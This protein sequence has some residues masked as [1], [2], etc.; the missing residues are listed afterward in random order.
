MQYFTVFTPQILDDTIFLKYGGQVGTSIPAQRQ[1]AYALAEELMTEELNSFLTP[2][3]VTGTF[4]WKGQNPIQLDFGWV[5]SVDSVS[6]QAMTV[7]NPSLLVLDDAHYQIRN[8]QYGLLDIIS[9]ETFHGCLPPYS[10]Q[11]VYTSGLLT[12]VTGT[13]QASPSILSALT[14]VAQIQLNEFDVSLSNESTGD[15][16][17]EF[18]IN[19]HYHEKRAK[20][21]RSAFGNSALAYRAANLVKRYRAK[22]SIGFH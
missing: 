13:V 5:T 16:G 2:T 15:V 14:I 8:A 19:Q 9:R 1:A 17:I 10:I 4:F 3:T 12:M 18:F 11:V 21:G 7:G 6:I 20:T 22:P